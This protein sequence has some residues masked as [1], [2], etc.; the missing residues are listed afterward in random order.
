M[1]HPDGSLRLL[2]LI[3]ISVALLSVA[4]ACS[5]SPSGPST[6]GGTGP[7]TGGGTTP[8][9]GQT[10][11]VLGAGDIGMCGA[12][13]I[14]PLPSVAATARLVA[15]LQGQ[16]ILAGDI[17]YLHGSAAN[18]RDCFNPS[19]GPF[20]SRWRPVP[21]NHEYESAGAAPYFAYFGE[22]AGAGATGYYS[23]MAGDWLVLMLNSNIPAGRGSA[24]FEFARQQLE[25]QR[26][27]CTLAVWH[28]PLFASGPNGAN[29]VMRD[30]WSLLETADAEVVLTGHDHLYERFARQTAGGV[31]D[32]A[33][34]VRQFVAGTGGAELYG[35]VRTSANSEVRIAQFGIVRFTLKPAQFEWEF[36]TTNGAVADSGLD[37]CH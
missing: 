24:Q 14:T 28:H 25:A 22:D 12:D 30:I 17:A 37:T 33:K 29:A 19:W 8:S 16:V 32:P 5:S 20:R 2:P 10:A 27:P 18:F 31:A 4:A 11:V 21:G 3:G 26:T 34:G 7:G 9:T 15:G 23:F 13:G 6:G 36:L 1:P 35:F